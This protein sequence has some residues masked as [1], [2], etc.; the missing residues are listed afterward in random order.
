MNIKPQI[1]DDNDG[2]EIKRYCLAGE[3]AGQMDTCQDEAGL[4]RAAREK[5]RFWTYIFRSDPPSYEDSVCGGAEEHHSE[6][7]GE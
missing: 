5:L 1:G 6:G 4:V 7:P 3:T 2:L